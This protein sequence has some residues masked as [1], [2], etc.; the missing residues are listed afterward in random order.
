MQPKK[1]YSYGTI[2]ILSDEGAEPFVL[3]LRHTAGNWGLPKGHPED[4]ETPIETAERELAEET[5]ITEA[6]LR[7]NPRFIQHY[8]FYR[9]NVPHQKTVIYFPAYIH[10]RSI[11]LQP[12]EVTEYKWA[13]LEKARELLVV[14]GDK[15]EAIEQFISWWQESE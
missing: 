11:T 3:V 6:E 13:S 8:S 2:P 9:G 5:G 1:E 7:E 14:N 4:T 10:T 15:N 12:E